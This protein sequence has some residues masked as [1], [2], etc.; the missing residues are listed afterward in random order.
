M[1]TGLSRARVNCYIFFAV[2]AKRR[3]L[4]WNIVIKKIAIFVQ[5]DLFLKKPDILEK[6]LDKNGLEKYK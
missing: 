6:N 3:F 2:N 1:L 5:F 4:F